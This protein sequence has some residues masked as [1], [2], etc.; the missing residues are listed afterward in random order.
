MHRIELGTA[1]IF[2]INVGDIKLTLSEI[3]PMSEQAYDAA[4]RAYLEEPKLFPTQCFH[5]TLPG[6]SILIDACDYARS[7]PETSPYFLADYEPPAD[8]ITQLDKRGTQP[9]DITHIVITHTHFDHYSGLTTERNGHIV[10]AFP[11]ARCFLSRA[12]WEDPELQQE[13][14]DPQS[15][16]S[17]TLGILHQQGLLE[18]VEGSHEIFPGIQLIPTPG[19]SPGHQ[20]VRILSDGQTLYCLGDLYHDPIEVDH[21]ELFAAWVDA[22]TMLGSRRMLA[23]AAYD[24][25]ALLI[26]SHIADVG[27]ILDT[28]DGF[29]WKPF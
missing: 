27:R 24:E 11:Y 26:A 21:P 1:T 16:Q 17:R 9:A 15:P 14:R 19:E 2:M 10:P 13:L 3:I 20:I 22:A 23:Q 28:P 12:D 7:F 25:H 8:L 29:R 4:T 5:A 6:A 18:V